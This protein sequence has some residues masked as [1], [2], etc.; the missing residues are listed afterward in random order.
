MELR[1]QA[2]ATLVPAPLLLCANHPNTSTYLTSPPTLMIFTLPPQQGVPLPNYCLET[3][4]GRKH[5]VQGLM[6]KG[7]MSSLGQSGRLGGWGSRPT[8]YYVYMALCVLRHSTLCHR[9]AGTKALAAS[10]RLAPCLLY[11]LDPVAVGMIPHH[12]RSYIP[13]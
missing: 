2:L 12:C 8:M 13:L 9:R 6:V 3:S 11:S 10:A 1:H 7:F 4:E 5:G